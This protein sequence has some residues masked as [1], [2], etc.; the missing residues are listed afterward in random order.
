MKDAKAGHT[1]LLNRRWL[2]KTAFEI[3]LSRPLDFVYDA[4]QNILLTHNDQRRHYSLVSAPSDPTLAICVNFIEQ[5]TFSPAL[6]SVDIGASFE[7]TGPHGYFVFSKS[8]RPP[9]FIATD[10]G[11]A[12]FAAMVRSGISGFTLLHG[13]RCAEEFYYQDLFHETAEKYLPF[14]WELPDSAALSSSIAHCRM[15]EVLEKHLAKGSYDFYLCGWQKMISD[16]TNLID[17]LF[18]DSHVYTEVFYP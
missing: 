12:P 2:S 16:V 10:T 1:E 11:I 8:K 7:L 13:A 15:V 3:E 5:G 17:N 14:V 18:P 6:A 4:G 9:V